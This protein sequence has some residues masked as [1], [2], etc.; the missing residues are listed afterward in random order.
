MEGQ[1]QEISLKYLIFN[2]F[3]CQGNSSLIFPCLLWFGALRVTPINI[4]RHKVLCG[5]QTPCSLRQFPKSGRDSTSM[6]PWCLSTILHRGTAPMPV[7]RQ[8]PLIAILAWIRFLR[9]ETIGQ[10]DISPFRIASREIFHV[11]LY[12]FG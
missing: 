11:D 7:A 1:E 12:H 9:L 3:V 10:Y 8:F 4:K 5:D 6:N 2:D